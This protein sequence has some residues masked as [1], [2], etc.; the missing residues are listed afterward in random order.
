MNNN[1]QQSPISINLSTIP[2]DFGHGRFQD[3]FLILDNQESQLDYPSTGESFP[4]KCETFFS[5]VVTAGTMVMTINLEEVSIK[6]G[7]VLVMMPGCIFHTL[8][9]SSDFKFFCLMVDPE[10]T[11]EMRKNVGVQMDLPHRYYTYILHHV[12]K[13]AMKNSMNMYNLIKLELNAEDYAF[14]KEVVQRYCEI[15][16]LKN[17]SYSKDEDRPEVNKAVS[18][19]EQIFQDFLALLENHYAQERSISFYANRMFLTPK[20]LSTVIK[21]VSGK[22]G[23]QWIDEYVTLEAKAL[24][25]SSSFSVKQVSDQLNFPSQSMFGRFFKKMTGYSPKQYKML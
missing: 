15:W 1:Y 10:F 13:E 23:M 24:L 5:L 16:V 20:Y 18:R 7:Q 2:Q 8:S 25:R 22:H 17:L 21:E 19:K 3:L 14:K 12:S 6:A 4:I 9:I 11:D